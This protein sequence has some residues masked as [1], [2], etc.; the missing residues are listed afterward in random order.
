MWGISLVLCWQE[1]SQEVSDFWLCILW[2][3]PEPDSEPMSE[4]TTTPETLAVLAIALKR[5]TKPT[6]SRDSI[7]D[8]RFPLWESSSTEHSTSVDMIQER[9][10]FSER[11]IRTLPSTKSSSSPRQSSQV[12]KLSPILW[13]P[14]EE[15][16]WCKPEEVKFSI[17]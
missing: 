3:S 11:A 14:S 16:W 17:V 9:N 6:E 13:T 1:V 5:S 15:D 12:Q 8:F 2:T 10:S 7:K 4:R